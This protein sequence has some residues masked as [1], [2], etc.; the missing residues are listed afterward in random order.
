MKQ[1]SD[2]VDGGLGAP[3]VVSGMSLSKVPVVIP[4]MSH[5]TD[6]GAVVNRPH[7]TSGGP[8]DP[9]SLSW[10]T[11]LITSNNY[12]GWWLGHPS[13]TYEFVNWDDDI[14]KINGKINNGNQTTNH[15]G[16]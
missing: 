13:E 7:R 16:L 11:T 9:K 4:R 8:A 10:R 3:R 2:F 1:L 5:S 12:A 14:P 15:Y 6:S